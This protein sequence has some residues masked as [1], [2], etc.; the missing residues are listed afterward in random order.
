MSRAAVPGTLQALSQ[1]VHTRSLERRNYQLLFTPENKGGSETGS[2]LP[3]ATQ[4]ASVAG[5][6]LASI[7]ALRANPLRAPYLPISSILLA[8]DPSLRLLY[9]TFRYRLRYGVCSQMTFKSDCQGSK[10]SPSLYCLCDLG[11][12]STVLEPQFTHLHNGSLAKTFPFY[13]QN[14]NRACR[15]YHQA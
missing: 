14:W 4:W 13:R 11:T 8:P 2:H 7:P 9:L 15:P 1:A 6:E 12:P 3:E 5:S 10:P